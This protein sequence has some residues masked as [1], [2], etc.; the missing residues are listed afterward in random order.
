M[1]TMKALLYEAPGKGSITEVPYPTCGDDQVIIKVMACGLCK[2]VE[3]M[4]DTKGTPM[5][6]YPVIPGHEF[7]GYVEEIGKNVKN[8]KIGDRVTADNT[9]LCGYCYECQRGNSLYC[10]NFG[11][12]GHNIN[13]GFAQYVL[14]DKE[15]VFEIPGH[16][17]FDEASI[18]EPVACAIHAMDVL[19]IRQGQNVL[20][21]GMGP[22]GLILAQ[23]AH[24]SNARKSAAVG[25]RPDRL[26]WLKEYGVPTI[27]ADRN[28]FSV[29][30]KAVKEMF[31]HGVDVIIDTAGSWP[32]VE[33]LWQFLRKGG[34]M[35]QY[36]SYHQEAKFDITAS[37]LNNLHYKEQQYTSCSCQTY[38]YPRAL[39]AVENNSVILDKLVSHV[40]SLDDYFQALETNK[41][42]KTAVKV[43]VHPNGDE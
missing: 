40:Y 20:V 8:V 14:V 42:D 39:E 23:L 2:W 36:G 5:S 11:S 17:S 31:P 28:D 34:K 21:I 33:N 16:I 22:H 18:M 10:E 41:A 9:V 12:L 38:C 30:E 25:L 37:M 13:G 3:I 43:I 1:K 7:A 19:D 6:K 4:H 15:K 32:M 35:L 24:H 27:L 29:H 26:E